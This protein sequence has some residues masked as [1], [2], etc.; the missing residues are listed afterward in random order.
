MAMELFTC[1]KL[2]NSTLVF[3][4]GLIQMVISPVQTF[5]S[6]LDITGTST[7]TKMQNHPT[8]PQLME[9]ALRMR[10]C[11]NSYFFIQYLRLLYRYHGDYRGAIPAE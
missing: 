2:R 5:V 1:R 7:R 4:L 8:N 3:D 9:V 6:I 10:K 11:P